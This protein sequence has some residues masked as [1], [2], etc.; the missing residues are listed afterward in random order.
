MVDYYTLIRF[1]KQYDNLERVPV[2][3]I[4]IKKLRRMAV[5]D[6]TNYNVVL[7]I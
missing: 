6:K 5:Y 4:N 7:E 1:E 2:A 3:K